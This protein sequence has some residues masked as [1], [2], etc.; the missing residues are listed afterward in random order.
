MTEDRFQQCFFTS[1]CSR[2]HLS[3]SRLNGSIPHLRMALFSERISAH[4]SMCQRLDFEESCVAVWNAADC[5]LKRIINQIIVWSVLR[6][7]EKLIQVS[8]VQ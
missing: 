8:C 4:L 1:V 3:L 7:F 2:E 5:S 6:G